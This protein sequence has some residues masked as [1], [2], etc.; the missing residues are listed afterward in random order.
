MF[1]AQ[2]LMS[3]TAVPWRKIVSKNS[4]LV[5]D[6]KALVNLFP[7]QQH[8]RS[9][10]WL[11]RNLT[12]QE[13]PP[14]EMQTEAVALDRSSTATRSKTP[15]TADSTSRINAKPRRVYGSPHGGATKGKTYKPSDIK[16]P[17]GQP[18][19]KRSDSGRAS[20]PYKPQ[21]SV[22]SVPFAKETTED[23]VAWA[24]RAAPGKSLSWVEET[25]LLENIKG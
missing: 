4:E 16:P 5:D 24:Q 9:A 18:R 22:R 1:V 11:R 15:M 25:T 10:E 2:S 21:S 6:V 8:R 17:P 7:G 13:R 19:S 12:I 14:N 20:Q 3:K 23:P